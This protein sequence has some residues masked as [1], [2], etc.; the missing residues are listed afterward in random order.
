MRRGRG[1]IDRV[2]SKYR[3]NKDV[4]ADQV[5]LIGE[6]GEMLGVMSSSEAYQLAQGR[7]LDLIEIAPNVKPPTCK[8]MDYG[9]WKYE[10][11]KKEKESRKKQTVIVVKE[12]QIR[13]RTDDHDLNVKL[14]KAL[15]F[16]LEGNKVKVNL[17]FSGREMAHQDLGLKLLGE[18]I[19]K[20]MFLVTVEAPPKRE[21]R[22]M[23]VLLAPDPV[24][25]KKYKKSPQ[26]VSFM[27]GDFKSQPVD[28]FSPPKISPTNSIAAT[29]NSSTA[30]DSTEEEKPALAKSTLI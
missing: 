12:I 30:A 14:R 20:L 22:Q 2:K 6:D 28:S 26:E 13:P 10:N 29:E 25:V 27:K 19:E 16:L 18:V 8:I 4:Q 24:K 7:S 17:R 23:F 15:E 9:K 11:K 21:G 3:I 1:K 5:R